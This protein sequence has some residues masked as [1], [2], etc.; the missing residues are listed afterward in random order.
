MKA[1]FS[2]QKFLARLN[3]TKA[4]YLSHILYYYKE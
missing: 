3:D 4:R 1:R 2:I